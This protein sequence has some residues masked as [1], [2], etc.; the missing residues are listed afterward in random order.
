MYTAEG[1]GT[2]LFDVAARDCFVGA[3]VVWVDTAGGGLGEARDPVTLSLYNDGEIDLIALA[4]QQLLDAGVP[5]DDLG[6]IAPYSAQV[7]RLRARLPGVE[8]N[9]VN[10]FQGREK[11]VIL[12]SWVRSN[13]DGE[14]GFVADGRRLTVAL[15]RARRLL[16]CVGDSATL[17]Y[18]A[19]F[20]E[21]LERVQAL[22][23]AAWLT[24]WEPPWDSAL[25]A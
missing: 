2:I 14:L 15:T 22:P 5:A 3:W 13:P 4:V 8:V 19:R 20:A 12:C 21:L 16:V 23:G 24:V 18:S 6:V 11:E 25:P 7:A 1:A 17:S 9:T 10:A